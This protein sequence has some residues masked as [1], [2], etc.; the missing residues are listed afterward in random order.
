MKKLFFL[1][2][3]LFFASSFSN[4]TSAQILT[5]NALKANLLG[6]GIGGFSLS[7]ER[8]FLPSVSANVTGRF[9]F[10]DYE[11]TK[12]FNFPT[13]GLTEINYGL[14]LRLIGVLPEVRFHFFSFTEKEAPDGLY[15]APYFGFTNTKIDIKSLSLG[16]SVE[17]GT[18]ATFIEGGGIIGY[19]FLF[20][21]ERLLFDVFAGIG[22]SSFAISNVNINVTSHTT[23]ETIND[24]VNFDQVLPF[25]GTL[26]GALPR[27]GASIGFTF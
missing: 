14:D 18:T 10:F 23:N 19:E 6:V 3:L 25:G 16:V 4:Q 13:L 2:A 20:L 24:F 17:G 9:L 7:Y 8:A 21:K 11:G 12:S 1:T 26:S 27:F 5:P 15:A 22:V